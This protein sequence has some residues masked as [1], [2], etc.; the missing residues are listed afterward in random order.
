MQHIQD[1]VLYSIK[2]IANLYVSLNL[3]AYLLFSIKNQIRIS[4]ISLSHLN[5]LWMYVVCVAFA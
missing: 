4:D 2:A 1:K 5:T 3:P